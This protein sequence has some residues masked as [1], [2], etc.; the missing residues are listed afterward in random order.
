[1][2]ILLTGG[3]S[4]TGYWFARALVQ[5]RHE[6]LAVLPRRASEYSS[7]VKAERVIRLREISEIAWGARFGEQQFLDIAESQSWDV[8]CHHFAR[9]GD[10]R[11]PDFDVPAALAENT[12][13]LATVL[14]LMSKRGL[15]GVIFTGSVFEQDE[16]VGN[17]PM[18]AFS[19][20]G[21]SKGLTAQVVRY[22]CQTLGIPLGKFV[23]PNPFGPFEEPR[24]CAYLIDLWKKGETADVRTPSYVR[25]N[26]HVDLL[27]KAYSR[28]VTEVV[29]GG[30]FSRAN[31]SG[32]VESQGAFATR[33]ASETRSRTGMDCRLLMR[34]QTEFPEP[35][36]R[37]NTQPAAVTNPD[38]C[39]SEAW[40]SMVRFYDL[41]S[42]ALRET[43]HPIRC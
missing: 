43:R 14:R 28:F 30:S 34:P 16:G 40:D 39:E 2:R 23:I 35:F 42:R 1:M 7:G 3:S 22:W 24:F 29:A 38:W 13:A 6:V 21:L 33:F 25:D 10:Y 17:E 26:I 9:V 37:I 27:A 11:S 15:K 4:F 12:Q 18:R 5:A 31:P 19:P 32:Y 41:P 36:I 8:F 20:Y